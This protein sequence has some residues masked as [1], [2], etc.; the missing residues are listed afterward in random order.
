MF[1]DLFDEAEEQ[2]E[3]VTGESTETEQTEEAQ[4]ATE[5]ST[6]QEVETEQNTTEEQDDL[7]QKDTRTAREIALINDL[8]MERL[9]AKQAKEEAQ[10]HARE[11]EQY[12]RQVQQWQDEQRR[13]QEL[14][15]TPTLQEDP[16]AFY[17]HREAQLQ[18]QMLQHQINMEYSMLESQLGAD[19]MKEV[20]DWAAAK[21][22]TDPVFRQITDSQSQPVR[23]IV[24]EFERNEML[25]RVSNPDKFAEMVRS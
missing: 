1:D 16:E 13:L 15:Q 8:R 24:Q 19:K 6:E 3:E 25:E 10:R 2:K 11:A 7:S 17:Q 5:E 22:Q 23:F 4:T 9:E 21:I 14:Y 18:Q 20:W 12:R